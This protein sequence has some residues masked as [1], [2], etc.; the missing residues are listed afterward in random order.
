MRS[1][2]V[3]TMVTHGSCLFWHGCVGYHTGTVSSLALRPL[4]FASVIAAAQAGV[5]ETHYG[6]WLGQV[7][8]PNLPA[9]S[10]GFGLFA[11]ADG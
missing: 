4:I 6:K 10:F 3:K 8:P 9:R 5:L 1:N 2:V 11:R 7:K